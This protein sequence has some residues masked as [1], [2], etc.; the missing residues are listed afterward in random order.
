MKLLA[1][2][3]LMMLVFY[4]P[5]DASILHS[6]WC[7]Y[8]TL[9]MMLVFYTPN[10]ASILHSYKCWYLHFFHHARHAYLDM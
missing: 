3:L 5:N 7:Q 6:K 8:F 10:D 9:Q 1:F 4:T 2:T